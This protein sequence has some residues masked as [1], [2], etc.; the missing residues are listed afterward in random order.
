MTAQKKKFGQTMRIDISPDATDRLTKT[1]SRVLKAKTGSIA[2]P[3]VLPRMPGMVVLKRKEYADS[4]YEE[5]LQ[6]I[7]DG[8]LI[9]DIS[10]KINDVNVRAIDFLNYTKEELRHLTVFNIISGAERSL[11]TQIR[12]NLKSQ[13]FTLI[14]A[15]CVRK[16]GTTFPSEIAVNMLH[17]TQE[18]QLCFFIRDIT[19]RKKAQL[20]LQAANARFRLAARA[21]NSAI[22]D[23]DIEKNSIT[24]HDGLTEVFGYDLA[25]VDS[26]MEWRV[27]HIHPEDRD[28]VLAQISEDIAQGIDFVA[29]YR[30]RTE[31]GRYLDVW[32]RG[33][34]VRNAEGHA[35]RMVGSISD[36]TERKRTE[37]ELRAMTVEL[38]R[39]N[40]ELQQFAY[41]ASHDLQEPLRMVAS[42]VQLLERRFKGQIDPEADEWIGFAV[43][44]V[45]RMQRLI[46]DLL[47]YSRVGTRG[48]E[49]EPVDFRM[50]V[51]RV[52]VNL[53]A[54]IEDNKAKVDCGELP[55]VYGDDLQLCQLLQ[56]LIGNAIKFHGDT[57]P[58]VRISAQRG[59]DE[60]IFCVR[61]NGVGI[62][63][64]YKE[65]IFVIFQRL[66]SRN[67]YQGTGIGLAICKKIVER[68]GGRIWVDSEPGKGSS[69][70]FSIPEKGNR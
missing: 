41:V 61:D 68:H 57:P 7:Y 52:L 55:V 70:C 19:E 21:V 32:D 38:A 60:W 35:A 62:D 45:K 49:F 37:R 66:H 36:I 33:R 27:E 28:R 9:T 67:Q 26:S 40:A 23:W 14:Q 13:R 2:T 51:E 5:L 47:E 39:S 44:G 65:R 31:E 50:V 18:G 53:K 42:F 12:E 59:Q 48:K 15:Y 17:L 58:E 43:D 20:E 64:Q 56:N 24:W 11:L 30:F 4:H 3:R 69:F 63:P 10:G 6:S 22:Y 29:E 46:N 16:D 1:T 25:D 54:T 8:V 34:V